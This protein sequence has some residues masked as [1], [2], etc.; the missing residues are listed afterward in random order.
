MVGRG[1]V[2]CVD[3]FA[4]DKIAEIAED[5]TAVVLAECLGVTR[6]DFPFGIREVL[7]IDIAYGDDLLVR[8]LEH[9]VQIPARSMSA[10]AD[11]SHGNAVAWRDGPGQ[12]QSRGRNNEG[13][14]SS[15]H[16]PFEK[17]PT[18]Y[19]V[20][21]VVHSRVS[22]F[23]FAKILGVLGSVLKPRN[24]SRSDA[25]SPFSPGFAGRELE[26]ETEPSGLSTLDVR[27]AKLA[28]SFG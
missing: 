17:T 1:N 15:S 13:R 18:S 12:S 20:L 26:S 14:R 8:I 25:N 28:K 24:W 11:Q 7:R 21:S 9:P 5:A 4:V 2:H 6:I 23:A 3:F 22:C 16:H 19:P 27:V 10:A